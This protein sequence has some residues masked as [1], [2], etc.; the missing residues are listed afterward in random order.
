M[1]DITSYLHFMV[2]ATLA[3]MWEAG[4]LAPP[5]TEPIYI[6]ESPSC[7]DT[8]IDEDDGE[9]NV[10]V[11]DSAQVLKDMEVSLHVPAQRCLDGLS[12][13]DFCIPQRLPNEPWYMAHHDFHPSPPL[14]PI[15]IRAFRL[16]LHPEAPTKTDI[17]Q[18][19]CCFLGLIYGSQ[20]RAPSW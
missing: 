16:L 8:C 17:L 19:F 1:H 9:E 15:E 5:P 6:P 13:Q 3:A 2:R 20:N 12:E 11:D 7:F 18:L 14:R 10:Q 4:R